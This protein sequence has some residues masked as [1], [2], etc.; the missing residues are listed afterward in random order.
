MTRRLNGPILL[1]IIEHSGRVWVYLYIG[2]DRNTMISVE[3]IERGCKGVGCNRNI[4]VQVAPLSFALN[5]RGRP[6]LK[7][8]AVTFVASTPASSTVGAMARGQLSA[9]VG[10]ISFAI[11]TNTLFSS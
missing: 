10:V 7:A 8:T 1:S 9:L 5:L 4:R 11:L 3:V 6:I 2:N